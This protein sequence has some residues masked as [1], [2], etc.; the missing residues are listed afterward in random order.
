MTRTITCLLL[1]YK[2]L[3]K[4]IVLYC[5]P[6][7]PPCHVGA[8]QEYHISDRCN[9]SARIV[10]NINTVIVTI[11]NIVT[12]IIIIINVIC[13]NRLVGWLVW[14]GCRERQIQFLKQN[15]VNY[16]PLRS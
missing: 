3:R 16:S 8:N 11:T 13:H 15:N 9:M 2:I 14:F 7:W 4:E 5:H 12:V 1:L 10:I 6:T